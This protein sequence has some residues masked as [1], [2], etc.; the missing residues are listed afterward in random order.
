MVRE[1]RKQLREEIRQ[2]EELA[3]LDKDK[4]N[5]II[6]FL[7]ALYSPERRRLPAAKRFAAKYVRKIILKIAPEDESSK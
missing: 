4:Q 1:R 3:A 6:A 2:D 5:E 7:D